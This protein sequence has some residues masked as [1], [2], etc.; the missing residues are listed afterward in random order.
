MDRSSITSP[1]SSGSVKRLDWGI[2]LFL[3]IL[4]ALFFAPVLVGGQTLLPFDNLFRFP[5]WSAFAAQF[6]ITT[7]H[8]ELLSDLILENYPWKKFILESLHNG[9]IPLWNPYLFAGVPFLAAG[10]HSALYPFSLIYYLLPL[11]R[12]YGVFTVVQLWLAALAMFIYLRVIRLSRFAA[13]LGAVIYAFSGFMIVSVVFP[14]VISVAA[15]LPLVLACVELM[16]RAESRRGAEDYSSAR[17]LL[18]A[19]LG[20]I[21]L[22]IQF[23]AGHIE[24]SYYVLLVTVYYALWRALSMPSAPRGYSRLRV[25]AR[26]VLFFALMIGVGVALG[27]VQLVPLYELVQRSFRQGSVT[28]DQVIGWAFPLRQILTFF[29]PDFFGNPAHHAYFDVFDF[30]THP[31]PTGTIFWGIK[32]YVES[33]AYVGILPWLLAMIAVGASVKL[34]VKSQKEKAKSED[35]LLAFSFA[36]LTFLSL[37]FSFGAPLYSLLYYGLPGYSQL[38]TPFRWVFPFTLSMAVLAA[39]GV[40]RLARQSPHPFSPLPA[41]EGLGVMAFPWLFV[42][43]GTGILL[44]L[45]VSYLAR[46]FTLALMDRLVASSDLARKVF[47]DGRMFYSYELRNVFLFALF[48]V[49]AGAVIRVSRCAIYVRGIPVWKPLALALVVLD[50]FVAGAPFN[51]AVDPKLADFVPPAVEFLQQDHSLFRIASYDKPDE[52]VFNPNVG[53]Y[54]DLAD[55]RGYDSII[56]KQYA[57][58]MSLLAPQDELLY[59]RIAPFYNYE[60][61]SSP[62]LDLLNVK[63]V[64][65]TRA[66]PNPG[67]TL[68]YDREIKIYRNENVLPRAFLVADTLIAADSRDALE[69]LK[70]LDPRTTVLLEEQPA[71]HPSSSA[72]ALPTPT[73]TKYS[74]SEVLIDVKTDT[75]AWLVLSDSYFPG[76]IAQ[77]DG[78]DTHLYKADY[79]FRAVFVPAGAHT[80]R[81]KYSLISFRVGLIIS[82]V[83][84]VFVLLGFAYLAWRRFY[85]AEQVDGSI[86]VVAKNSLVP[87]ATA[88]LNK[89]V[90]FAFA[91]FMLRVLGPTGAG[92]YAFAIAVWLNFNTIS[93]FGL[94][95]LQTREVS[96]DRTLAN[97]FLTNSAVL[98]T[99]LTVLSAIPI[100]GIIAFYTHLIPSETALTSDTALAIWLLLLSLVPQNIAGSLSV[101]FNAYERFEFPAAVTVLTRLF[102][103]VL[104]V[105][106]LLFGYG[107]VGL[108]ASAVVTNTFTL[109]VI[110][111]LVRKTLFVPRWEFDAKLI[112]WMF[113]ES[114]PLMLNNL[115]AN[116]FFR[117]DVYILKPLKGDTVLGY[118]STAYK[119]VDALNFIPS[120]FTLAIFPLLSRYAANSKDA[121]QR[122]LNLSLKLLLWLS[123]PITVGTIFIARELVLIF[124]GS[125]YLPDSQYALQW[126][127]WFLPFSFINSVIHYV[128]IALNQQRFLTKAFLIGLAFN[129]LANLLAIPPLSY[130]GAALVTVLS[131]FALLAP[132]YYSLR[133]NLGSVPFLQLAWRP[134]VAAGAM[135]VVLYALL[136]VVSVLLAV[137]LAGIFYLALLLALGALGPDER[138]L[139]ARLLPARW[140]GGR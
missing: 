123:L 31:A 69:K 7:P 92:Q 116:L 17:T 14:M 98:R 49:G 91:A 66:V 26:V 13:T 112:R 53:M 64:L 75:P 9:E 67:Y 126:L 65:S 68:V 76:W 113:F 129:I 15:W 48:L 21:V 88:L 124:G 103:L 44:A 42:W 99:A 8:N 10:Q 82:F 27:A 104:G 59:N 119:F 111:Y 139:V 118:Y 2:A 61:L 30:T 89:G 80:V 73:I 135:G 117:I 128:L 120:N 46:D 138:A 1:V 35:R 24:I 85:R 4:P 110:Y 134:V 28:L 70:T 137:P 25:L 6:G 38:H 107:F 47:S 36:L 78:E 23:L 40:D 54:Y 95:I 121:M 62:L 3:L 51:P 33:G 16:I 122:A 106:V 81:F 131:E 37:L 83:G 114:Y 32:N 12:A 86:R 84:A 56:P 29:I 115:L 11:T 50:L 74:A 102:S 18:F 127:I 93:D 96:R 77:V 72:S 39:M 45:G 34:K 58:Y 5:P 101:L 43:T 22:G 71:I 87:M 79:N 63:Y 140:R 60:A 52:K 97:R 90:D 105:A 100:A 57:D 136:Q 19:L 109:V 132:F 125:A 94:G 20:A 55:I 108:A 133:K 41:G 130:R